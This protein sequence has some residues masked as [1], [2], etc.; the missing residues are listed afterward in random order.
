MKLVS[1]K[2]SKSCRALGTRR[3]FKIVE[4]TKGKMRKQN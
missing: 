3:T 2:S 4:Y 1:K